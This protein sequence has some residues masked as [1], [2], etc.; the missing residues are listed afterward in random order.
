MLPRYLLQLYA[1][2]EHDR[3]AASL[4]SE[5]DLVYP[6]Y[7]SE[8]K[9]GKIFARIPK[10]LKSKANAIG[11]GPADKLPMREVKMNKLQ[12]CPAKAIVTLFR[13]TP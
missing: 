3:Q 10:L 1:S 9:S 13:L 5:M 11:T 7:T 4:N 6:Q 12:G 2:K 8:R